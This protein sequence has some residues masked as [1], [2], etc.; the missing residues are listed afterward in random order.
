MVRGVEP[1]DEAVDALLERY[2]WVNSRATASTRSQN[3]PARSSGI[4]TWWCTV[5]SRSAS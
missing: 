1:G 4:R 2:S 3:S 5:R